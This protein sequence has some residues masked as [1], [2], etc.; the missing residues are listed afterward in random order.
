MI[1]FT[2]CFLA[3]VSI[4]L[5]MM[6]IFDPWYVPEPQPPEEVFKYYEKEPVSYSKDNYWEEFEDTQNFLYN[7]NLGKMNDDSLKLKLEYPQLFA[8]EDNE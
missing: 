3:L 6:L 5:I 4:G 1:L 8:V 7:Y 2:S